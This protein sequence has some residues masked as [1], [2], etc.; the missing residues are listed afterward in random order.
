M[1][2]AHVAQRLIDCPIIIMAAEAAN[3]KNDENLKIDLDRSVKQNLKRKEILDF[4][5]KEYPEYSWSFRTLDRR[6]RWF[7]I[8][9]IDYETPLAAVGA[10]VEQ[11]L[12]G[13]GKLL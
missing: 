1:D 5:Q 2:F 8:H 10:A 4:V 9:Y 11:E 7:N 13:P 6:L 3:W 12:I